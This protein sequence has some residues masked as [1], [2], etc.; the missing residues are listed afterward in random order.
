MILKKIT[1][2]KARENPG[3]LTLVV[4]LLAILIVASSCFDNNY[5]FN[6]ISYE[7]EL[8]PG[9]SVPLAFGSLTLNDIIN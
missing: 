1:D 9:I 8:T 2:M 5:D 7:I 6:N 3:N 4:V